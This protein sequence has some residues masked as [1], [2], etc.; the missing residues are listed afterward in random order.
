VSAVITLDRVA[1]LSEADREAVRA[2][3]LAVYPPEQVADWPGRHLEWAAPAWCVR[4]RDGEGALVCYVGAHLREAECD[5][6][7]VRVGGVG[8]VKTH[9]A[10]RRRGFAALAIRRAAEFFGEQ[11]AGFALLVCEPRLIR[12]YSR[13]GWRE[14]TGRLVVRQRGAPADFTF[15]RVMVLGIGSAPPSAGTIDLLGPP[16]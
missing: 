3:S 5:G 8:G 13:L 16:W 1:D 2:L 15:N 6:R 14:F 11:G 12:Y 10:A 9:P 7:A 4:V